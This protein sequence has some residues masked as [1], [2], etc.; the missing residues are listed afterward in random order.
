MWM[1]ISKTP[2][3]IQ[4]EIH[5]NDKIAVDKRMFASLYLIISKSY[6]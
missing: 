6:F 3:E 1:K 4:K 5:K 2:T